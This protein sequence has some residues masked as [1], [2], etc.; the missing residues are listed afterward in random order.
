MWLDERRRL[1]K[2]EPLAVADNRAL[3]ENNASPGFDRDIWTVMDERRLLLC[4]ETRDRG[5]EEL[6][7]HR[8]HQHIDLH[9]SRSYFEDAGV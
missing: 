3:R 7:S 8:T 2:L 4:R 6:L 5:A 1:H 9:A